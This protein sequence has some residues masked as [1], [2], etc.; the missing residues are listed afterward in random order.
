[1]KVTVFNIGSCNGCDIEVWAWV[2]ENGHILVDDPAQADLYLV[3]GSL[4]AMN[5]RRLEEMAGR[6]LPKPV[7]LIGACAAGQHLF[8]PAEDDLDRFEFLTGAERRYVFGCPPCPEEI[9]AGID[10][11]PPTKGLSS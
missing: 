2:W 8:V 5:A 7:V 10:G 11:Q 9:A 6:C 4:T 3:T 1:M